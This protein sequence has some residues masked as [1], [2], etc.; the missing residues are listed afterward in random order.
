MSPLN[1][2]ETE[3]NETTD[4]TKSKTKIQIE[5]KHTNT[6][7]MNLKMRNY[8]NLDGQKQ[9]LNLFQLTN[10]SF[11]WLGPCPCSHAENNHKTVGSVQVQ[12]SDI[13]WIMWS[14]DEWNLILH[15]ISVDS[16]S[17]M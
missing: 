9:C 11:R 2:N 14:T 16:C 12:T 10:L 4:E 7:K 1:K 17:L 15:H 13:F 6:I 8:Y 3:T 5:Y